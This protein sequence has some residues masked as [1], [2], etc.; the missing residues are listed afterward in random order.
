MLIDDKQVIE[1]SKTDILNATTELLRELD[2]LV[3]EAETLGDPCHQM[4][5]NIRVEVARRCAVI[6]EHTEHL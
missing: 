6:Q 2:R 3:L 5:K 4:L 1:T